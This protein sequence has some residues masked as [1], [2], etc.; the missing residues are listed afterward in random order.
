MGPR[1]PADLPD[2]GG[3]P[4]RPDRAR[5]AA[6]V[7]AYFDTDGLSNG[8]TEAINMRMEKARR[9]A[10]L[11]ELHQLPPARAP[12]RQRHTHPARQHH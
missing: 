7:L 4:A 5:L 2:P 3:R 1:Q 12:C 8:G 6:Q 10:R 9:L 11:Q